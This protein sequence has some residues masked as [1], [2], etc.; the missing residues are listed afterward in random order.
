VTYEACIEYLFA[1]LP[2]F[3]RTGPAAYKPG[4][5][6]IL[7]LCELLGHPERELKFVHIAGTNGKGSTSHLIASV[8]QEAGYTTGLHTSPH[9]ID[10][11]ERIRVNGALIPEEAVVE[12]VT[13]YRT[14]WEAIQPSF[15]ELSVAMAFW[16]FRRAGTDICVIETGLGGR[17]DST[18]IIAPEVCAITTIGMDHMNLLGDTLGQIAF[19][20][21]GIIKSGVP[22]V[23]GAITGEA[24]EVILQKAIESGA[25]VVDSTLMVGT[26]EVP[27]KGIYQ[28]A[29]ARTAHAV[30]RTLI[31]RG[32]SIT[33]EHIASGFERVIAHTGLAG[34]W[35]EI[36]QSPKVICDVG[37]NV[38]GVALVVDQVKRMAKS[39]LH[40]VLGMVSDKDI[41]N[42]LR[43][44]PDDAVYYFCK[45]NIPR[46][47]DAVQ[48]QTQASES[49][50][51]GEVYSS[52]AAAYRAALDAATEEDIVLVTGSF[53]TV[54]EVLTEA[55][56]TIG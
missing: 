42:V 44:L 37:H 15:F 46:G 48:L 41:G 47:M 11:R 8:L 34:R 13:T 26:P 3:H 19:E 40:I 21:A 12:F 7:A 54:G 30:I 22:V 43:L 6:N 10:F 56:V 50:L 31:S 33:Q 32:W 25:E 14:Q 53:F 2:M 38:D 20:K 36:R 28:K 27:L 45:A 49:G 17:L 18:N 51:C 39:R 29:N 52:V 5:G 24:R 55:G 1:Q 35:Q 9:L 23:I 16:Y 4:I